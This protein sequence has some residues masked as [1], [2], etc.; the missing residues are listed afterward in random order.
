LTDTLVK[1]KGK[2]EGRAGSYALC[3]LAAPLN[4][5]VLQT[6]AAGP[7]SL[8]DLRREVGSPPQTTMRGHM[9]ALSKI[10]VLEKRRRN[11]FPGSLDYE[12]T[13]PGQDLMEVADVLRAWLAAA[14]EG[15]LDLGSVAAKSAIKALTEGWS[16]SM[17]RALAARPLSLTELD[18][19]IVRFNYPSLER[20]LAAMRLA[21]QVQA[22]PGGGRGTPYAVTAWLRQGVAP[23]AAAARWEALYLRGV[24]APAT[25][26]DVEATFLLAVPLLRLPH[27]LSGTCRLAVDMGRGKHEHTGLVGVMVQV[28]AGRIASCV[29]SLEGHAD[30]WAAGSTTV[31][32]EAIFEHGSSRLE[33]GGDQGLLSEIL[34]G[35]RAGVGRCVKKRSEALLKTSFYPKE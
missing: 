13:G 3:L 31:W 24:A 17:L 4:A 30:A 15:P 14:P 1:A 33:T 8:I 6:L 29:S 18:S 21:G 9:Q 19:L 2:R 34:D 5:F 16:T 26:R 27:E 23:I 25:N 35:L 10:G 20:R 7:R 11:D 22:M 28:E 32:L 12:L